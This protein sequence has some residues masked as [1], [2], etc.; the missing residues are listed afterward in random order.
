MM[1]TFICAAIAALGLGVGSAYASPV[2]QQNGSSGQSSF[3]SPNL[4]GDGG[5]GG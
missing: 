5:A 2:Q 1:K 3:A 4:G